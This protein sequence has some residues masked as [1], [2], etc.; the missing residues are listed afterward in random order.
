MIMNQ[1]LKV[2]NKAIALT[3]L[4]ALVGMSGGIAA[5]QAETPKANK[6]VG[7][8]G[9]PAAP[10]GGTFL[11]NLGVEPTT[12]NPITGTDLYNQTIQSFVM[13]SLMNRNFDT[14]EWEPALAEK[15]EISKDGREFT[16]TLRQGATWSDGK[17]ITIEDVK[18]SFDVIFDDKYNAAHLRPY[19]ENIEKAEVTGTNAIKF[20]TKS[21][22]FGNFDVVAGLTVLPKHVY[23]DATEGKK[24]NKTILGSGP[25]VLKE[26]NQGQ[27][28][29]L[30]RNKN[31]WGNAVPEQRGRYNFQAIRMRF[32]K[33]ENLVLERLKKGELDY[34]SLTPEAYSLK[35]EGAP[36]GTTVLKK[37]V[38]NLQP[39]SYG[40]VGWNLT[41]PMF[42]EKGVRR[43][44]AHLM[45]REEM[46]KKFRFGMSLPAT[47][48]WYQQSEYADPKVKA[49]A[50]DPKKA[51][52]LLKK[53]GWADT[54]KDGVLDK[55][56]QPFEF[57][58]FYANKDI[59]KYWVLYQEDLKK[60]GVKMNLQLLEWNA[61]LKNLDERKF[62]AVAL[63]WGGGSVDHN[64]KQIWHTESAKDGGSNRIGYSNPAVDKLIDEAI[65]ELDKKKRVQMYRK[66][67][68]M[69]AEDAPYA[70]LFNDQ[71]VLYAVNKRI[72]LPKDT[73]KFAVGADYW[74]ATDVK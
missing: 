59:Q 4:A 54:N 52:E 2:L 3:L 70:F 23:G 28:I 13:D 46:N 71:Y 18:F 48:P 29:I 57:T 14:Y 68:A 38:Q 30:E 25:F 65:A 15:V 41:K 44:L 40:Y 11:Y 27:A 5:A 8:L 19:Y 31:W 34:D 67:Y 42:Q 74:W 39:K 24:K 1:S 58:L 22:Y 73:Y 56:G 50:F 16:F 32:D 63:G 33:E 64:P 53:A 26:Y 51:A 55:A 35:T 21:K 61:L 72:G 9:N 62:D 20:V 12:L 60:A 45:N 43:A 69:I 17:P 66:I 37:K 7:I 36:W 10:Q 49:I 6:K 47:G